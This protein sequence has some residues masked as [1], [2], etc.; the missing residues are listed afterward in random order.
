MKSKITILTDSLG[1]HGGEETVLRMFCNYLHNSYKISIIIP[2]FRG[3]TGYFQEF[4][5]NAKQISYN[6]SSSRLRMLIF[7]MKKLFLCKTDFL[8]TMT[9][10]MTWFANMCKKIFHKKYVIISWQH[11]SIF[12]PT[13]ISSFEKKQKQYQ[14]A[15]YYWAISSGIKKELISLGIREKKIYTIYNPIIP[16]ISADINNSTRK[17][18][19]LVI[20]RIQFEQ[21]KNLKELFDACSKLNGNWVVDLYGSDDS[22][23]GV[24][25][26]KC[27]EYIDKLDIADKINWHG[28]YNDVW[29]QI[30]SASCLVLTSNFEGFPMVLCEAA[31]HGIPLISSN[32]P[33]GPADIVNEKNGFLYSM[34]DVSMLTK[35]MQN[36]V[37]DKVKFNSEDVKKSISSFYVDNYILRIKSVI[38]KISSDIQRGN[39]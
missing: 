11:F 2:Q 29:S 32:C 33:T 12:S 14:S 26:R 17:K 30:S 38:S 7:V 27:K 8:V 36:F 20:A 9:P 39:A 18:H 3:D 15:N 6:L 31:S 16:S 28:W 4:S 34:H 22:D 24:E 37:D 5:I 25:T 23:G 21:Q 1:G 13:E 19:F 35:L 10:R